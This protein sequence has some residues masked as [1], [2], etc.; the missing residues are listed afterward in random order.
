M[1]G[2]LIQPR[3]R[4]F[5]G[6][7]NLSA[8]SGNVGGFP[9]GEPLVYDIE[10]RLQ[11]ETEGP[12]ASMKWNPTGPAMAVYESFVSSEELMATQIMIELYY[13]GGKSLLLPFIWSGQTINYGND[14]SITV[15]MQ[16]ELSG[17]I[18]ANIRNTAQAD[19]DKGMS[20]MSMIERAKKQFGLEKYKNIVRYTKKAKQDLEKA[21]LLSAYGNDWTFGANIANIAQQTGN[22]VFANNI[23]EANVV[24]FTPFSWDKEGV[25]EDG[26]SLGAGQNP[27]PTVR[28]GYLLGPSIINSISRSTEW[29]PPQQTKDNKP[30][31]QVLPQNSKQSQKTKTKTPPSGPQQQTTREDSVTKKTSSPQGTALAR[32]NPGIANKDNPDAP[33]KQNALQDEKVATLS[34]QTFVTP[35]LLGVKPHD[36]LYIPDLKGTFIEDWIVQSVDY[37]QSDGRLEVSISATRVYGLGTPMNKKEAEKFKGIALS[38][39]LIGPNATLSAWDQYAWSLPAA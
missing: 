29:K 7:T 2:N 4:V 28:Y 5:W 13:P 8:Y 39:G 19:G 17:L 12:T 34:M 11:A 33:D 31:R 36:I 6:Q 35:V 16:S 21:K 27:D 25:V 32:P 23:K 14:M 20:A 9:A 15:K 18:N 38:K 3:I 24:F 37:D 22:V 10:V 26:S 30:Q 1:S